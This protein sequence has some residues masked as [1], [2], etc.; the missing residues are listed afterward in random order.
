MTSATKLRYNLWIV[1]AAML[2]S[3]C[4][5]VPK[6]LVCE[7]SGETTYVSEEFTRYHYTR[8]GPF[9]IHHRMYDKRNGLFQYHRQHGY[10]RCV[11]SD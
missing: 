1:V 3:G 9:Q 10:E 7:E 4:Y 11:R 6:R 2:L 8:R 5:T